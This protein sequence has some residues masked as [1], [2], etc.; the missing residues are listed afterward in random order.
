LSAKMGNR[1]NMIAAVKFPA[2]TEPV[3]TDTPTIGASVTMLNTK[4]APIVP[5]YHIHA[6]DTSD[7]H[8][9]DSKG[10]VRRKPTHR[11]TQAEKKDQVEA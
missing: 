4:I 10:R 3:K 7:N 1:S 8:C 5:P 11:A 9:K 2:M 6:A